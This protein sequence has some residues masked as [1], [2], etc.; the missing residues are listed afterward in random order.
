MAQKVFDSVDSDGN[1][2]ITKGEA[3]EFLFRTGREPDPALAKSKADSL[4]AKRD[5]NSNGLLEPAEFDP[6]LDPKNPGVIS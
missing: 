6:M 1:G 4:F 3:A 2:V 5:A